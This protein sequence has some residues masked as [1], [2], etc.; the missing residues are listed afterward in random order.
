MN[1]EDISYF[2]QFISV[3]VEKKLMKIRGS[4]SRKI[5]KIEAQAK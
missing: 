3:K 4:I 2:S 5:K 1:N